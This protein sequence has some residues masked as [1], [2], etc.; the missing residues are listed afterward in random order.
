MKKQIALLFFILF[1]VLFAVFYKKEEKRPPQYS[2]YKNSNQERYQAYQK[3][4]PDLSW[5]EVV[6]RVNLGLDYPYYSHVRKSP[7]L[8]TPKVLVNK[9]FSLGKD[10]VPSDLTV[11]DPQYAKEGIMLVKEA[12]DA[13]SHL[14]EDARKEGVTIR[15]ISSY[16][17]YHYQELLYNR[18]VQSDGVEK[19]DTYSARPGFSEHQTGLC[20]DVDDGNLDYE[21]FGETESFRW[22]EKHAHEYG[23]ILRY[24]KGKERITGYGYEAWHYRYVGPKIATALKKYSLTF[25]EYFMEFLAK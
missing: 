4:Y 9:Y 5:K 13:F 20:I 6:V 18:Y 17:S 24:P 1:C 22:M 7:F 23:F 15:G 19:A 14:A 21:S 10:Y 25:D 16:R 8:N 11:L 12:K 2:F 3:K